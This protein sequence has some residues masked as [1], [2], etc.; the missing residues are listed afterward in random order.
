MAEELLGSSADRSGAAPSIALDGVTVFLSVDRKGQCTGVY[1]VGD[2]ASGRV[3]QSNIWPA[4]RLLS[5]AVGRTAEL[6]QLRDA[7]TTTRSYA[8]GAPV[9]ARWLG[10]GPSELRIGD[11]TP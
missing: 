6:P 5:Q 11:T 8:G 10:A 7:Q 3:I 4:N 1:A 9:V 2:K